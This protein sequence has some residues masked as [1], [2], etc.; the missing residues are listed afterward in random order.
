MADI[1]GLIEG[2]S[3]NYGMGHSFLR[4]IERTRLLLFVVDIT[5]FQ[6][7]ARAPHQDAVNA[8]R[9]LSQELELYVAAPCVPL[10]HARPFF[11]KD[12]TPVAADRARNCPIHHNLFALIWA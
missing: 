8:V 5:G 12:G 7:S 9:L 1:P 11:G 4:H 3:Q 10:V 2:A 6:L